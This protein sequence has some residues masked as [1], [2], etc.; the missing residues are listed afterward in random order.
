QGATSVAPKRVQNHQASARAR[1]S[2]LRCQRN[3]PS[4]APGSPYLLVELTQQSWSARMHAAVLHA[5]GTVP[6]YEEFPDPLVADK[7]RDTIVHVQAAALKPVDRQLAS[8]SHYASPREL[9]CVCG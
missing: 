2:V 8:G 5:T 3:S 9:S 6:H 7:D 1:N 4:K